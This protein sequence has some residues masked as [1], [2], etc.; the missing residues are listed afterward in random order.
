MFFCI[1][2][3]S[4]IIPL[5]HIICCMFQIV[6]KFFFVMLLV[7]CVDLFL[8]SPI[9]E[10]NSNYWNKKQTFC[11]SKLPI[12]MAIICRGRYNLDPRKYN[13][14][15]IIYLSFINNN[16]YR[17]FGRNSAIKLVLI[18]NS[19][20]LKYCFFHHTYSS[21]QEVQFVI[22]DFVREHFFYLILHFTQWHHQ[23][24]YSYLQIC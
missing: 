14:F 5:I 6:M 1:I 16:Q 8:G 22:V 19:D 4:I 2:G 15:Y 20:T 17:T 10:K 13:F 21:F 12:E 23:S 24:T 18:V 9:N 3:N 7:V 11:G